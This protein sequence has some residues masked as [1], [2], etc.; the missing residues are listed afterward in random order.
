MCVVEHA[1]P[2]EKI[3][4]IVSPGPLLADEAAD[5]HQLPGARIVDIRR[6]IHR[7]LTQPPEGHGAAESVLML[8]Q[9]SRHDRR[10]RYQLHER[11]AQHRHE[12]AQ[13]REQQMTGLVKGEVDTVHD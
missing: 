11:S 6:E 4:P 2:A 9:E 1:Q 3:R 5:E 7:A 12:V 10:R 8:E 13:N